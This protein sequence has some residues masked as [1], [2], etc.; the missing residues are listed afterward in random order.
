MKAEIS[1]SQE[2]VS[3]K[4]AQSRSPLLTSKSTYILLFVLG[5]NSCAT[6]HRN[7]SVSHSQSTGSRIT[8][9]ENKPRTNPLSLSREVPAQQHYQGSAE[10]YN[11]QRAIAKAR[12]NAV[13]ARASL[14]KAQNPFLKL[15]WDLFVAAANTQIPYG[16]NKQAYDNSA[17]TDRAKASLIK[18]R[19]KIYRQ[20]IP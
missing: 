11:Q 20:L 2:E 14:L 15:K 13:Y 5:L 18:E 4:S 1:S 9:T 7:T 16:Y 10:Y 19:T 3:L 8:N 12:N 6:P 17:K